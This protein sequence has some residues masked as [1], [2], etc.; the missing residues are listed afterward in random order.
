MRTY[1]AHYEHDGRAW[2]VRFQEPDISTF[3]RSLRAA[4]RY[5]RELLAAFLEVDDLETAGV[6]VVDQVSLPATVGAEVERLAH[7]RAQAD[8]LR[9]EVAAETRRAAA[10][11][12]K[13]GLS[14][15]DAGEILG[16][17]SARIAQ[18]ARESAVA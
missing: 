11:L 1:V 5:A 13:S 4:K 17:S 18:I 2:V 12:R 15:R 10:A 9:T 16:I 3:G 8:A 14:T 7:M 6:E